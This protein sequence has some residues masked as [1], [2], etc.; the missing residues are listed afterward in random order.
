MSAIAGKFEKLEL[1]RLRPQT[2]GQ[3]GQVLNLFT[4]RRLIPIPLTGGTPDLSPGCLRGVH[5][6][7]LN[8]CRRICLRRIVKRR[9]ERHLRFSNCVSGLLLPLT[10]LQSNKAE[11]NWQSG[12]HINKVPS[13]SI[14]LSPHAALNTHSPRPIHRQ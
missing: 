11:L 13:T 14:I 8:G 9:S 6:A 10:F 7:A 12:V 5:C 2:Q 1:A 3:P 4:Q